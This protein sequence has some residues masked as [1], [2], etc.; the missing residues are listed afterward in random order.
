MNKETDKIIK[1]VLDKKPM[2]SKYLKLSLL[3]LTE[4]EKI[5]IEDYIKYLLST[6]LDREYIAQSY[7]MIVDELFSE[8]IYFRKTGKYRYSKLSQIENMV[9]HDDT[10][11]NKYMIGLA[12]TTY[13][14]INHIKLKRF[15]KKCM[16]NFSKK[17]GI[18]CE[19]GPGHGIYFIEVLKNCNFEKYVGI[20][21]SSTS[22]SLT[23]KI[24]NSGY[25]GNFDNVQLLQADFLNINNLEQVNILVMGEVI[26]HV[27]DPGQF[28]R[29]SYEV[30]SD[31]SLIFLTTCIN[32]PAIDHLYNPGSVEKLEELFKLHSFDIEDR[33]IISR[34][35]TTLSESVEKKLP[36]NVAYLLKKTFTN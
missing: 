19:I 9:Y 5:E 22:I 16:I 13:F 24:V 12:I 28:L 14:W 2:H 15:F 6:G 25:F 23:N 17:N 31:N 8:E 29:K 30:T 20:D 36:I 1:M 18:Y 27:E 35:G 21:I 33:C 11:M 32:A 3:E 26:E 4:N 34:A 10:Y 7:L